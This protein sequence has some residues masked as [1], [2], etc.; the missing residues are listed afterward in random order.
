MLEVMLLTFIFLVTLA[1][2]IPTG[3]AGIQSLAKALLRHDKVPMEEKMVSYTF[4]K[5]Y[6]EACYTFFYYTFLQA[7][8]FQCN[9]LLLDES[10]C[11]DCPVSKIL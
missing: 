5:H 8:C 3:E 10:F 2:S 7:T 4:L 9:I 1:V 6:F 11:D